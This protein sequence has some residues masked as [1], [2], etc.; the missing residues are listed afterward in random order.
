MGDSDTFGKNSI[1][2]QHI[3]V[4]RLWEHRVDDIL[5]GLILEK[6]INFTP[7]AVITYKYLRCVPHTKRF[8]C[9]WR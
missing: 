9:E 5:A 3:V 1:V 2:H 8:L 6:K 4:F 7:K